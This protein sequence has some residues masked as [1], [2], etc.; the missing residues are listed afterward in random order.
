[1]KLPRLTA[2]A[3]AAAASA[4]AFAQSNAE[5]L[6][7]VRELRARVTELEKKL[8]APAAPQPGQWGMTPEQA[9]ELNRIAVKTESLQDNL[10][11]QGFKGLKISG[12]IDPTYIWT[13]SGGGSVAFLN[14]F[15]GNGGDLSYPNDGYGYDNSYFGQVMLDFQK[16]TED[17]TKWRLTLAPQKNASSG[18][19]IG[20][21]VHEAS[22]SIELTDSNTRLWVGQIP[23]WSGYEYSP[24]NQQPLVTHNLLFDF[25]IPSFY[26][27]AAIDYKRGQWETKV[28]LGNVN[29][30]RFDRDNRGQVLAYRSDYSKGEYDGFGFAG[31]HGK[32][33]GER[34]DIFEVDGYYTRGDLSLQGQVGVGRLKNGAAYGDASW[35]GISGLVAYNFNPRLKGIVRADYIKNDKNG[36]GILGQAAGVDEFDN[37]IADGRNGFGPKMVQDE[38]EAWIV[39]PSGKGANRYALSLGLAYVFNQST[40]F[41]AEYRID[42]ANGNVFLFPDGSY[43]KRNQLFGAAAVVSF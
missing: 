3:L 34:F 33:F 7:M 15:S 22:A 18:Y 4:P 13:K 36:G 28:L 5:L 24:A 35:A 32:T 23:D 16:E 37:P 10:E 43:K 8:A 29:A 42:G 21:V 20:S 2:V 1:M 40:T 6:N 25:T 30:S 27:G 19:N 26:Q 11:E 9:R 12:M 41:K 39:D 38:D 14:G 31:A 17:G